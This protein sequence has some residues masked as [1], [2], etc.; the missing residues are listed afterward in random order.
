MKLPTSIF[1]TALVF[2][3]PWVLA[4]CGGGDLAGDAQG[5]TTA[6][7]QRITPEAAA[8]MEQVLRGDVVHVVVECCDPASVSQAVTVA[9]GMQA[10]LNLPDSAPMLVEGADPAL[11]KQAAERLIDA[12]MSQVLVVG[13]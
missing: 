12:G 2:V 13:H 1:R 4:G 5:G 10:A 6:R 11:A 3:L 8:Q 9:W 7:V